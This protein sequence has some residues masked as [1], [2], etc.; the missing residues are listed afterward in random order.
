MKINDIKV[1]VNIESCSNCQR[2]KIGTAIYD[3]FT[4]KDFTPNLFITY[5]NGIC[6]INE[7]ILM[8]VIRMANPKQPDR[9][10]QVISNEE[11]MNLRKGTKLCNEQ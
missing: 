4:P 5:K 11:F 6:Y 9:K 1:G 2:N 7:Q 8:S 3:L 10:I